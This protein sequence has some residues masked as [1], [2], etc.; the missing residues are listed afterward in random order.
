M[1]AYTQAAF[2]LAG[3]AFCTIGI[4]VTGAKLGEY[5]ANKVSKKLDKLSS[6]PY[7]GLMKGKDVC[8]LD[9]EDLLVVDRFVKYRDQQNSIIESLKEDIEENEKD[10]IRYLCSKHG[11]KK[12]RLNLDCL[13]L[14]EVKER[15]RT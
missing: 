1:L 13:P 12:F 10:L 6:D 4:I 7:D 15:I 11:L 3:I 2:L 14:I 5:Y 8:I 9:D